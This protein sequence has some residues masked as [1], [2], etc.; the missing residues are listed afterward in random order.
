MDNKKDKKT[1]WIYAVVLFT[2]AFIVL[3]ITAYSQIKVNRNIDNV[4]NELGKTE[5]EKSSF[6]MNL[7]QALVENKKLNEKVES[8]EKE[9]EELK[10]EGS[11]ADLELEDVKKNN[12]IVVDNYEKLMIANIDY[13]SKDIK[14]C[15]LIL[16]KEVDK[17]LL[18]KSALE[19]YNNLVEL[20]YKKASQEFY[21]DGYNFYKK[22][23]YESAI[24]SFN[25][26][27][28][29]SNTEYYSDDC[30]YLIAYSYFNLGDK[31]KSKEVMN[32][33]LLI[34]PDSTYKDDAIEFIEANLS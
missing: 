14:K 32:N 15:A 29:L 25:N 26:S 27:L 9:I 23:Q 20:S 17:S 11:D 34:Y 22:G 5:Q 24:E 7:S 12:E 21:N 13:L 33:L 1:V 3:T 6:Q 30:Y 10:K 16:Y 4:K 19:L 8:L 28:L 2:S 18:D 31:V